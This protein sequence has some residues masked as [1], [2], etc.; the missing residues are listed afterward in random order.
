[1]TELPNA[2]SN[3]LTGKVAIV[4]GGASGIG[5]A[6]AAAFAAAGART[7]IADIDETRGEAVARS[8]PG[9]SF[10]RLDV[11][12]ETAVEAVALGALQDH[13]RL[14]IYVANAGAVGAT[15]SLLQLDYD[16]WRGT[17]SL[18]LDGVFFGV[19]HAGRTMQTQGGGAILTIAS[20]AGLRGGVG[21]HAYSV[22]KAGV[23]SLTSSAAAELAASNIRVNCIAPGAVVTP[24]MTRGRG[25]EAGARAM[26]A[27]TSLL[28][29]PIFAEDVAAAA[30]HLCSEMS[31]N[32]TGQ[33]LVIDGGRLAASASGEPA[34][35]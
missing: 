3:D 12:Q 26:S 33:T 13:G 29:R 14:D 8:L 18:L 6:I 35:Y 27:S 7:V 28:G 16:D 4:T 19:K 5:A 17:L 21:P 22:A 20:I 15:G 32:V 10:R 30:L 9:A 11:R 34:R 2:L 23:I 24:L 31:R 1:M 25:G